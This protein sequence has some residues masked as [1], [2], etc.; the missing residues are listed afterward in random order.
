MCAYDGL[1]AATGVS[2]LASLLAGITAAAAG[3]ASVAKQQECE[4]PNHVLTA[5]IA[6]DRIEDA[7]IAGKHNKNKNDDP[8]HI[9]VVEDVTEA[10]HTKSLLVLSIGGV[11]RR[12]YI[13]RKARIFGRSV[14]VGFPTCGRLRA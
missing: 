9:V 3:T 11:C 7:A 6:P 12:W 5:E 8:P 2:R 4:N 10:A 13:L 14:T 1:A